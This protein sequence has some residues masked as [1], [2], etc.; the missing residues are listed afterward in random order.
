M[1]SLA[2][3]NVSGVPWRILAFALGLR[4]LVL[5]MALSSGKT[6]E[7]DSADYLRLAQNLSQHARFARD[8][9]GQVPDLK[10]TPVYPLILAPLPA[11]K[12]TAL[13]LQVFLGVATV[14]LCYKTAE[15]IYG[16][17]RTSV[18]AALLLSV[19][20]LSL[21]YPA[22][23]LSEMSFVFLVALWAFLFFQRPEDSSP[24]RLLALFLVL[25]LAL[26]TRP[27][28]L[29]L[30]PP[31]LWRAYQWRQHK[32][33]SWLLI[34]ALVLLGSSPSAAW[35]ARNRWHSGSW[36]LS[37][38]GATNLLDYRAAGV[39]AREQ[40]RSWLE[41]RA[42]LRAET[43]DDDP[44]RPPAEAVAVSKR[45]TKRAVEILWARKPAVLK[46]V[47]RASV[48]LT[49]A[50][51][52]GALLKVTGVH[53]GGTGLYGALSQMDTEALAEIVKKL[54]GKLPVI[55]LVAA[56]SLLYLGGLYL[57]VGV[58][59][60]QASERGPLLW[61]LLCA[62]VLVLPAA[63]PEAEPRFRLPAMMLLVLV[64]SPALS[65]ALGAWWGTESETESGA[66][67]TLDQELG[68]T[69]DQPAH[70]TSD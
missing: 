48:V 13:F 12:T 36:T 44:R 56:L 26:L 2:A 69:G 14:L 6:Q 50:P 7:P 16:C 3:N 62:A 31:S 67:N 39:L 41:L 18:V 45:K 20:P 28:A 23:L 59:L 17:S 54:R 40:G 66:S 9:D 1:P 33:W 47:F 10:R 37:T 65:R 35:L 55:L 53:E 4:L 11:R 63:G 32:Q 30:I 58:S 25:A 34:V 61:A 52:A 43:G 42:E 22:L 21:T 5:L 70:P 68:E 64:A 57:A 49:L 29:F 60:W 19:E 8:A 27:L 15:A 38:I 46:Q 24:G 51:G